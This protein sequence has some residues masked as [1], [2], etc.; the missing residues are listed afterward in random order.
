[1][2][3]MPAT[4]WHHFDSGLQTSEP[5]QREMVGELESR[6]VRFVILETTWDGIAEPN[7]S[8]RSSG[9]RVL[10]DYLR[11]AYSAV[12]Q[13]GDVYVLERKAP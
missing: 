1:M 7:G 2:G 12:A 13:F 11:G 9:V 10:D 8:G 3:R 4:R 6:K 5:I